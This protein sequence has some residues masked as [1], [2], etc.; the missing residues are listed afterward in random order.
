MAA[1][2]K[3]VQAG[4][5]VLRRRARE[6]APDEVRSP[7]IQQLI[8]LMRD[9]MRDA[10]GVGLAA[11]QIGE[12]IQLV[13]IEDSSERQQ[14]LSD[15]DRRQRGREVIDFHVLI[16]PELTVVDPAPV[17]FFEGCLSVRERIM[18]VPRARSVRV[19]ALDERGQTVVRVGSGWYARILQHE[20]DHLHGALCI[21]HME[22]RSFMSVDQYERFWKGMSIAEVR[23]ELGIAPP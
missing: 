1:L 23:A 16:N 8:E 9:T 18:V 19:K 6:L 11:P 22:S 21:D 17:D 20:I 14:G 12:S 5:P 7:H 13:V 10:P 4:D 2:L 15:E 3:I